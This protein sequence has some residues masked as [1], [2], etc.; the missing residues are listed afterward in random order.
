MDKKEIIAN[1]LKNGG[2][3][4]ENL[5]V[6]NITITP[7]DNYTRVSLTIDKPIKGIVAT[8]NGSY[9]VGETNIVYSSLYAIVSLLKD[10]ENVSFAANHINEHPDALSVILSRATVNVIIEPVTAGQEYV[11]PWSN[12]GN[13]T[14]FEH[15]TFIYH[16]ID[17]K[18]S[19]FA[20]RKAD[21]LADSLLGI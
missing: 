21:K 17:I 12:S 20:I 1:L 11:N 16:I 13:K 14:I 4:V 19:D 9:E 6:K 15:D 3:K 2:E 18:L 8:D 5:K 7:K 10:D